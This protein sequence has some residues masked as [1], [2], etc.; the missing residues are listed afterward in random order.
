MNTRRDTYRQGFSSTD[1]LAILVAVAIVAALGYTQFKH[2]LGREKARRIACVSN[3][4]N[5]GLSFRIWSGDHEERYPALVSVTN[6]GVME[7]AG[8]GMVFPNLLVMSNE[9]ATPKIL[10]CPEERS[11]QFV[12]TFSALTDANLSYFVNLDADETQ[13]Q[14]LLVGDRNLATN[15]VALKPGLVTL[16]TNSWVSWTAELHTHQGNVALADGSVQQLN[17][18]SLVQTVRWS[19]PSIPAVGV[20]NWSFRLAIP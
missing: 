9:L 11:R 15:T 13:P 14:G 5:I 6:G 20:T 8:K 7:L 3:Q 16:S 10:I 1:L 2:Y 18:S 4:K 17:N 19:G 12:T